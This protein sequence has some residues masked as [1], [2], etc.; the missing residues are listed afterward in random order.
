M[1]SETNAWKDGGWANYDV[2]RTSCQEWVEYAP[3]TT[4]VGAPRIMIRL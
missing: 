4:M 2:F 1:E 3:L